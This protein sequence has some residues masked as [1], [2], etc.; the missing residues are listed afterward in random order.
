MK[1]PVT[2]GNI[3]SNSL[4]QVW[5]SGAMQLLRE[6]VYEKKYA[7]YCDPNCPAVNIFH[8]IDKYA[9]I[10][11]KELFSEIK[12]KK[13]RLDTYFSAVAIST[14]TS[15]NLACIMC[16]KKRTLEPSPKRLEITKA[17]LKEVLH[18]IDK[19][20]WLRLGGSGEFF[21]QDKAVLFLK[22]LKDK[23]LSH[24]VLSLISNGTLLNE[25]N[26]LLLEEINT[27]KITLNISV[28]AA[29]KGTYEKIRRFG[30]WEML[31]NNLEMLGEK[32][33]QKKIDRFIV[34]FVIMKSNVHEMCRFVERAKEWNCDAVNF[35]KIYDLELC[36]PENFFIRKEKQYLRILAECLNDPIMSSKKPEVKM[37]H[38]ESY[39]EL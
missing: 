37:E 16:R 24:L 32:R 39:K 23:D 8:E 25:R 26:W 1:I 13:S 22:K 31:T 15:C 20:K 12:Q 27:K 30:S 5:N 38:L 28:D 10:V 18:N 14:D 11:G 34:N 4:S 9:D 33:S 35:W 6:A 17:A 2:V 7:K 29:S 3:L 19:I 21:F 36:K